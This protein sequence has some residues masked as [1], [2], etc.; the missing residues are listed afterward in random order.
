MRYLLWIVP[1]LLVVTPADARRRLSDPPPIDPCSVLTQKVVDAHFP[2]A[3]AT[4]ETGRYAKNM[5]K[6]AWDKPNK[7]EIEKKNQARIQEVMKEK[8]AAMRAGKKVKAGAGWTQLSTQNEV[9]LS[10]PQVE[11]KSKEQAK[12]SFESAVKV[13]NDGITRD[14]KAKGLK[15]TKVTFQAKTEDVA[16]VGDKAVWSPKLRELGV[17]DG[18]RFFWL[19]VK[20]HGDGAKDRAEAIKLAKRILGAEGA[21]DDK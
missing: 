14:V 16:G 17:L 4:G 10:V 11:M 15:G 20:V 12:S 8:M 5:C 7:A 19:G 3:H 18:D 9:W 2:A 1:L 21:A 13:I 6:Y